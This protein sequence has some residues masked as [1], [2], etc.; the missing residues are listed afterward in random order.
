[1]ALASDSDPHVVRIISSAISGSR[2]RFGKETQEG[3][4]LDSPRFAA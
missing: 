3:C 4:V 1:M 2:H